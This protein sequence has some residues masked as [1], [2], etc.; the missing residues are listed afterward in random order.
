MVFVTHQQQFRGKNV[1][2]GE[3]KLLEFEP[4]DSLN[5]NCN[6]DRIKSICMYV[7]SQMQRRR[8]DY[9]S[10]KQTTSGTQPFLVSKLPI[11]I[12]NRSKK[13]CIC[14]QK[15]PGSKIQDD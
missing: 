7:C 11:P 3:H 12:I 2:R 5:V 6:M 4:T 15:K 8:F 9:G 1:L 14:H 10:I 13:F